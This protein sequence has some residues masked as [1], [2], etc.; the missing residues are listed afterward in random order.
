MQFRF[1]LTGFIFLIVTLAACVPIED[2]KTDDENAEYHYSLGFAALTERNPTEALKEFLQAEK[3]NARDPKIQAALAQAYWQ[4]QAHELAEKHYKKAIALSKDDPKYYNNLAALYLSMERYDDAIKAFRTAAD[5]LL[6]DRPELAWAGIGL[7][8]YQKHD[9]PA[10]EQAYRKSIQLNPRYYLSPFHLGELY[11]KQDRPVEALA[12]FTR[13]VELAP[14]F[15]NG[16]Y[17]QGLVYMKM[18]DNAK[19]RQSF[20]EVVRLAP[21]SETGSLAKNYLKILN[22]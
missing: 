11:F 20:Q 22:K 6:F 17:W 13:T 3:Y 14:E 7:A 1:V 18:K 16:H 5:N 4:K 10:A 21:L 15:P 2:S 19:A 9:Y 12:M 8:N